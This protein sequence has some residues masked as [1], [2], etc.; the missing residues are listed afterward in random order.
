MNLA[1]VIN[2]IEVKNHITQTETTPLGKLNIM[3]VFCSKES[4]EL[5]IIAGIKL[6]I[7]HERTETGVKL[8]S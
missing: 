4:T 5:I 7:P 3:H 2:G 8:F 1:K 6:G